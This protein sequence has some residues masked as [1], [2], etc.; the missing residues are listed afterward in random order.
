MAVCVSAYPNLILL[1]ND[2]VRNLEKLEIIILL[3]KG[4][5]QQKYNLSKI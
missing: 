5:K 1:A 3:D 2:L 4:E